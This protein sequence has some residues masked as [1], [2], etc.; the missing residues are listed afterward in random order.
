MRIAVTGTHGSGKMTLIGDFVSAHTDHDSVPEPYWLLT[1]R[2]M[3][4]ADGPTVADLEEQ[5]ALSCSLL[6]DQAAERNVIYDRSPLDFIA[7][8]DVVSASEGFEW[9]P[10]G[11]LLSRI[12]RALST[13]DLIVFV[14]LQQPD[15]IDVPIEYPALRAKVDKRLKTMLRRDDLGLLQDGPAVLELSGSRERRVAELAARLGRQAG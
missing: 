8:L 15:D 7:Y 5:L 6:L 3:A 2:G 1:D 14:P 12:G 13:L 11:R 4:F 10:S 9:L